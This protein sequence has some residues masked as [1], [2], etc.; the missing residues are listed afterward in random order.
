M[1]KQQW[2]GQTRGNL[3]GYKIVVWIL[4]NL[5][6]NITYFVLLFVSL[7]FVFFSPKTSRELYKFYRKANK[8]NAFKASFFIWKNYFFLSQSL[9]DKT[10]IFIG[11]AN[12][13]TIKKP[14][15][16]KILNILDKN[17]PIVFIMTHLGD[18]E[19]VVNLVNI[20]RKINL[21]M[22]KA[23]IEQ[24]Q[25]FMDGLKVEKVHHIIEVKSDGSHIF[26][27]SNAMKNNE[28][29]G[30]H[31]DRFLEGSKTLNTNF[32]G[33]KALFTYGPFYLTERFNANAA[34]V[35]F[36]KSGHKEYTL[37]FHPIESETGAQGVLDDFS[38]NLEKLVLKYP[39]S[40]FN[41]HDFWKNE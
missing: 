5:G 30:L 34:L 25:K 8:F 26:E 21:L 2:K 23:E 40:W 35:A 16:N 10:A 1:A 3:L 15:Y 32:F 29:I 36:V 37:E 17:K 38:K 12:Q 27:L 13:F 19:A 24:V 41:Y 6:L 11:Q 4:R 22:Y 33:Q 31:G 9:V 18:F 14:D 20:N 7:Y 39:E 28:I